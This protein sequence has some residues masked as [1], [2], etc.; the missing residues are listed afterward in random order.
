MNPSS[1][2]MPKPT[3]IPGC[4][5]RTSRQCSKHSQTANVRSTSSTRQ[6]HVATIHS[7]AR[8]RRDEPFMK[9]HP[10]FVTSRSF[11]VTNTLAAIPD[12]YK[13]LGVDRGASASDIKKAYY[14]MAKKYHPDTNKDP[15]A[16]EKFAEAQSAYELL[17]DQKKRET[18][19]RFGSAAFDQNGGFDPSAGAGPG[20]NPFA[21]GGGF[22]GFGGFGGGFPGGF[23]AD[24]NFEDLFGAFAGG[25]RRSGRGKRGP[26]QEILVGEDIEVQTNISFMEAAKGTTKDI[27]INPLTEC[28]TCKG[29]GLKQGSKRTQCRQCNGSGTRVHFM[30]GGFQIAATCDACGGAGLIVPRGSECG[31][32]KGTGVV[33][34]RKTVQVDI[35]GGVED[36]MRLRISGEGDTPPTGASAAPGTRTQRGDLF[37]SI[38]V[39]PDERFSRS[40]SDIL[41][42]ASIPL[43]TALLGGEVTIPTLEGQV[44]VKVATGTGTGDRIT[45]SGMGMKKLSGRSR[46]FSPNGDLKVE[47]KVAM[48]K[49]LTDN[50]RTI[51]EVLADEMGDKSAKRIMDIPRPGASPAGEDTSKHEGF[52]KSAWHK[53]MNHK[54]AGDSDKSSG[55]SS[56]KGNS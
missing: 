56:K 49:Y 42:T 31:G 15:G 18:Y 27:V 44:K 52:L 5:L 25:A 53:L 19:D 55:D 32:C 36:G 3:A 10:A 45:L 11:H 50:Q 7:P 14:G 35:P 26:F 8:R 9:K 39:S 6:Y 41:Y 34:D 12:P 54:D 22:H 33:R 43:T 46:G 38:R 37:V 29:D 2:L 47:F 21:G 48:P 1:V 4:I 17:S 40:G 23:T 13:V 28:G 16:K 20:A 30:Q 24:I 51:L